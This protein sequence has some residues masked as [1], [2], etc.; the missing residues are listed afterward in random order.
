M[1]P[2]PS[3]L[4]LRCENLNPPLHSPSCGSAPRQLLHMCLISFPIWQWIMKGILLLLF[5][6]GCWGSCCC[7]PLSLRFLDFIRGRQNA[8]IFRGFSSVRAGSGEGASLLDPEEDHGLIPAFAWP[9]M[10]RQWTAVGWT[11]W[12]WFPLALRDGGRGVWN[13]LHL[14]L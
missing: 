3:G 8:L 1:M 12:S 7:L 10:V 4:F 11:H 5:A 13:G 6:T 9:A 2:V 14:L